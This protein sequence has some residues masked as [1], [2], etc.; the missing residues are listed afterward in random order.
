[1]ETVQVSFK[2]SLHCWCCT[3]NHYSCDLCEIARNSVLQSG[4]PDHAKQHWLGPNYHLPGVAGND[5]KRTN[6][7][8]IRVAFR[9]ETLMDELTNVFSLPRLDGATNGH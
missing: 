5:V 6:I 3:N 7:P 9:Y 8:N 2:P 4:F 1:M